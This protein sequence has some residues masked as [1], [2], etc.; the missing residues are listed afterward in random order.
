MRHILISA[1][2]RVLSFSP[3]LKKNPFDGYAT[4]KK[5]ADL[6]N[7]KLGKQDAKSLYRKAYK[8]VREQYEDDDKVLNHYIEE[9][10]YKFY[11]DRKKEAEE[12]GE[13]FDEEYDPQMH[14]QIEIEAAEKIVLKRYA[15]ERAK[16]MAEEGVADK[17]FKIAHNSYLRKEG[18]RYIIKLH[19]T[20]IIE[21]LPGDY[22]VLNNG[23]YFTMLTK[24]RIETWVPVSLPAAG[25]GKW[26]ISPKYKWDEAVEY[27][28]DIVVNK[29]GKPISPASLSKKAMES[30]E[31]ADR[32]MKTG[33]A[34]PK[35]LYEIATKHPDVGTRYRAVEFLD[36]QKLLEKIA[37]DESLDDLRNAAVRK[38][39]NSKVLFDLVSNE[40]LDAG[41]R[42][43]AIDQLSDIK[44]LDKIY[45]AFPDSIYETRALMRL[46]KLEK[47][48][49]YLYKY[50]KDT[51]D[52]DKD[53][54]LDTKAFIL[55]HIANEDVIKKMADE[56]LLDELDT[57]GYLRDV[58]YD[59]YKY[60]L[61]LSSELAFHL[62]KRSKYDF[63]KVYLLHNQINI[64][65]LEA[66]DVFELINYTESVADILNRIDNEDLLLKVLEKTKDL[67]IKY[68]AALRMSRENL[69][70][71]MKK[72]DFTDGQLKVLAPKVKGVH[73]YNLFDHYK[74]INKKK[75]L[76]QE[77][78]WQDKDLIS[79]VVDKTVPM[80]LR[81]MAVQGVDDIGGILQDTN[82]PEIIMSLA[83]S[84]Y[85]E[86]YSLK[87]LTELMARLGKLDLNDDDV[88]SAIDNVAQHL[89]SRRLPDW[90]EDERPR[91][92][93]EDIS[94]SEEDEEDQPHERTEEKVP[95]HKQQLLRLL[96]T[97]SKPA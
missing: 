49:E 3:G 12:A 86:D 95:A 88:M 53:E 11:L 39:K 74:D 70:E 59:R 61:D 52:D 93:D 76:L 38:I 62:F 51:K 91:S 40:D 26:K 46:G 25:K 69:L 90:Y 20:D 14:D 81:K 80:K 23:D 1:L 42:I 43:E 54:E 60:N 66:D 8:E 55:K 32:Y 77:G 47:G 75:I 78:S 22:Y 72:T 44:L 15:K 4:Y 97:I 29:K 67:K 24:D 63:F 87:D 13:E 71:A 27:Y 45:K 89:P 16:E 30:P 17:E 85:V 94:L 10:L 41:F 84:S 73:L 48:S 35:K 56:G 37:R 33:K 82:E 18:D 7:K 65:E 9:E 50:F 5:A 31:W 21:I 36:N 64:D 92:Y 68:Y 58:F 6:Y 28:N 2:N 83:K 34:S 96:L 79:I 57:E 19:D